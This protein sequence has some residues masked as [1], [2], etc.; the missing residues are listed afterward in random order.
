LDTRCLVQVPL[1]IKWNG[2]LD[3]KV[4]AVNSHLAGLS[5]ILTEPVLKPNLHS[6]S[7]KQCTA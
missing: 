6:N 1:A 4:C 7:D 3:L 5:A 2:F